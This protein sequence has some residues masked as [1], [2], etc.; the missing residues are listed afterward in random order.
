M[1]TSRV[2]PDFNP[3]T[4]MKYR[5]ARNLKT[6]NAK[7][8]FIGDSTFAG[9][10]TGGTTAQVLHSIPMQLAAKLQ[11]RGINAGAN[12]RFGAG[13]ALFSTLLTIDSRVTGTGAW[14]N[15]ATLAVGGNA[16]GCASAGSMTFT[17]QANVTKFDIWW[18]DGAAGR[19]FSW[20]VDAGGA[21]TINSSGTTQIVKTTV[22]AGAAGI[23][24]LTLAWV[25]GSITILGIDAYDD[26]S[27][28]RELSIWNWGISG[29]TSANLID[30]TDS[31][32]GRLAEITAMA[33]DLSIVEG[34]IIND[35][36]NSLGTA[37]TVTNLTTLFTTCQAVGDVIY[38]TP[39][40][41]NAGTGDA[42]NQ[43]AYVA[44]ATAL[45]VSMNIPVLDARSLFGSFAIGNAAG[46]YS[47]TVHGDTGGSGYGDEA[48]HVLRALLTV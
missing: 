15:T 44:A 20:A 5:A 24:A 31:V 3:L 27:S 38:Y 41:D 34:G 7:V 4:L 8:A 12:N 40:F 26:T 17:P 1:A 23:H 32:A 30:N 35:W 37:A 47:D 39:R 42:A 10:E 46:F 18:R 9:I 25:A 6:R 43:N 14:S 28:R 22:S 2:I 36:R 29:A 19:N 48:D 33:P 21:T 16:T 11:A 13:S 45:A